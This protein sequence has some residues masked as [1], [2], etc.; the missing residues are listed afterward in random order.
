VSPELPRFNAVEMLRTLHRHDVEY[1]L[2]GGLA[3]VLHGSPTFTN[4][5]DICPR[6]THENLMRLAAALRDMNARIR[7]DAEPDGLDFARDAEFLER[8]KMLNTQTDYGWFDISFEPGGFPGGYEELAPHAIE[9][10]VDDFV[11]R[12]A[13]LHDVIASKEAANRTKDQAMLPHLYALEDEIAAIERER[14]DAN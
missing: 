7:T 1:V 6:R 14:R 8:M 9:Y 3:A 13:S 12:V 4:D 10:P 2:I 11:V 5:A